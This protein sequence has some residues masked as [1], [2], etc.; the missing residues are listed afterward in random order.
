MA[1]IEN[2]KVSFK[3]YAGT[4]HEVTVDVTDYMAAADNKM[5]LS[6]YYA[7][8]YPTLQDQPTALEQFCMSTGIRV[9]P[10]AKRGIQASSMKEIMHGFDKSA[11]VV[12]RPSG[13]D[14]QTTAGRILFPE[15]MLQLINDALITNKDSY[16]IPWENAIALR[17]SV[18][19]PRIDQPRINVIAP[20]SSASQ[21][22]AQLAEPSIMVNITVNS[23]S[24]TIP[25]KSIGLQV[26]DQ[27]LQSATVDFVALAIAAQARGERIRRLEQDIVNIISGDT[28]YGI[29]AVPFVNASTFDSTVSGSN[30]MTH[31][32][33]LKYLVANEF[34]FS[35]THVI[36]TIDSLLD[37]E[38]RT[39]KPTVFTDLS[40]APNRLP[41]A[42]SVENAGI[43][44]PAI[45]RVPVGVVGAD[46]AVGFD[47]KFG[48]H[49]ITNVSASYSA[50]ENFVMRRSTAMRFDY[51]VAVFKLYDEAFT[52]I[53]LGA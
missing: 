47:A 11:G 35:I 22:I 49:E 1:D 29:T 10:D 28:D 51:G 50:I 36:T 20:E 23:K 4:Q 14:R 37:I 30:K 41:G 7:T 9:R 40:L 45:L 46:R 53:T 18:T 33:W 43:V 13:A 48:L 32:A 3:D 15:I 16:L 21:P 26:A 42:Y 44:A 19:G 5:S 34:K 17:T 12:T 31:K 8:K 38:N 24:Y 52:G 25:T 2:N 6:Q 27:A 39:G